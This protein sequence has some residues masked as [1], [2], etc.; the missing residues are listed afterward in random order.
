MTGLLG[1]G[2]ATLTGRH[3]GRF[4][5]RRR[6]RASP[7]FAY[8]ALLDFSLMVTYGGEQSLDR[9]LAISARGRALQH[10]PRGRQRRPGAGRRPGDGPDA[11]PLPAPLRVR[12]EAARA[13]AD[14]ARGRCRG[15]R[16]CLI[17]ALLIAGPVAARR[18]GGRRGRRARRGASPGCAAAQN[19]DGGFGFAPGEESSPA[20]TGW[21]VLGLE[22][23]G[24]NP[25]DV[26]R[27]DATPI[28]Y[29]RRE[30]RR[31]HAPPAT[32]SARSS[33]SRGAGLD[34]RHFQGHDLVGRLLARRGEDGSWGGQVNQTAFGILALRAA[35]ATSGN[36][37]SAA[38]LRDAPEPRRRLGLRR[39]GRRA[40]PTAPAPRCRRLAASGQ[41]R[42][43]SG[44][45]V[46]YL[47][48]VQRPGGGF[49]LGGRRGQRPVDGLGGPGP[50]RRG[51]LAGL[52]PRGRP[53]AARLP[54]RASRPRDGHYRYSSSSDQTPVWVTGQ[55]L[56]AV[57]G[58]RLPARAGAQGTAPTR[59][60]VTGPSAAGGSAKR[61]PGDG[62]AEAGSGRSATRGE[63]RGPARGRSPPRCPSPPASA[64]AATTERGR[65]P[66][67]AD[68]RSPPR[69]CRGRGLGRLGALPAPPARRAGGRPLASLPSMEVEEAIRTRRTHKAYRPE[70]V[71][72][73]H[74]RGAA[75]PGPLGPQP[76][77]DQSLALPGDRPAGAGAAQGGRRARVGRRSSTARR[78]WSSAPARSPATRSR[79]RRTCTPPPAPPTSSCSPPTAAGSP[80]YWRTPEVLRTPEGRAAV[81]HARRRALRRPAPPRRR[82]SRSS[83][84]R[85]G[86]PPTRSS[87]S[88]TMI[89]RDR[90]ARRRSQEH[91]FDVVVSAAASPA[92][93]WR[94]TRP[95]AATRWRCVERDD[96]GQ[97]T[98]SRSSKMVHG[99]L[100]YLQN[101]D[102]GLVREALLERQLLVQLAPHLVY[103]TPFLVPALG[104]EPPRPAHRDRPEHVRRDGD[105]AHRARAQPA[106][107]STRRR[108]SYWSPDRHRTISGRGGRRADPGARAAG[109][110]LRLPLLRLPDR[111]RRGWC[112]P[113]SARPS[114]SARWC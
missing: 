70:P 10:R 111:R 84:R 21:A 97:G 110:E 89:S 5:A 72:R 75:R 24:V 64:H 55:A 56:L 11:A 30:R 79:T 87:S 61:R 66:G 114:A 42:R 86:C 58:S 90:R 98:S 106:Q 100:R 103:P 65:H 27:G 25:L 32:S 93:A 33:S 7:G 77:P 28:S 60:G 31:D 53:L 74:A 34:P 13:G 36:G 95:R 102:L 109:P 15:G 67:L 51:R 35:G 104:E 112:S 3:V 62:G 73:E 69:R 2:L 88:S 26:D 81:G 41:Q 105:L 46:A 108:P 40:T 96:F 49:A 6:L 29:L 37:R 54:R 19:D 76:Q 80:S 78:P 14:G 47:R 82:R 50:G 63:R 17:A 23:A 99:G 83:A 39:R 20:M 9:F 12:L 59:A 113:S 8:G 38:W 43:R 92:P 107:A 91:P 22:A 4:G 44:R 1:A 101:F 71:D 68:R 18:A 52:G 57:N 85:S 16:A 48:G 45:G 94:S